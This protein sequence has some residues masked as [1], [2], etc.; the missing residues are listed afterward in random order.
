[1]GMVRLQ[2]VLWNVAVPALVLGIVRGAVRS[3]AQATRSQPSPL[4]A[5]TFWGRFAGR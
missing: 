1:M 4:A 5:R 3:A 2:M